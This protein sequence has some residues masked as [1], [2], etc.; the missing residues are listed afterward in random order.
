MNKVWLRGLSKYNLSD[1]GDS[2]KANAELVEMQMDLTRDNEIYH[3]LNAKQKPDG[4]WRRADGTPVKAGGQPYYSRVLSPSRRCEPRSGKGSARYMSGAFQGTNLE[5]QFNEAA[6]QDARERYLA[7]LARAQI[8][9]AKSGE[10]QTGGVNGR[11]SMP[12]PSKRKRNSI[13]KLRL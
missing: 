11:K 8:A 12:P 10:L 7:R 3:A 4:S 2:R 1:D 9:R 5:K 13:E 6:Q